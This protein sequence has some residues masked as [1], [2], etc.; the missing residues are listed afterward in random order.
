MSLE[1]GTTVPGPIGQDQYTNS[2]ASAIEN[3]FMKEW[4][5]VM[6]SAAPPPNDQ[7]RLV[8]IAVAQGILRYFINNNN[9]ITVTVSGVKIAVVFDTT[10]P[11]Y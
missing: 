1:A 9:A 7:M 8:F 2:L 5:A 10:G 11:L 6:K 4:P 3:A